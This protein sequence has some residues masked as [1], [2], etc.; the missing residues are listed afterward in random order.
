MPGGTRSASD[1]IPKRP[2]R[3]HKRRPPQQAPRGV[4]LRGDEFDVSSHPGGGL[5]PLCS[6]AGDGRY[7][8]AR[9]AA[10]AVS[11]V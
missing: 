9:R 1:G 5:E 10:K 2:S 7:T 8:V 4:A 11:G 6:S 3:I